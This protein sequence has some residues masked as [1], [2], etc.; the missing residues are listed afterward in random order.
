[1]EYK[2]CLTRTIG[3]KERDAFAGRHGKLKTIQ[4]LRAVGVPI[5]EAVHIDY[6]REHLRPV[7][8][9]WFRHSHKPKLMVAIAAKVNVK[10][11]KSMLENRC[12]RLT[13]KVP[14]NPRANIA[15]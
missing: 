11:A 1:M 14:W 9:A 13:G 3:A 8:P 7:H 6:A 10:N 12:T 5:G 15:R 4:R 2:C